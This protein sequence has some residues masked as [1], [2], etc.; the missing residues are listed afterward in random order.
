LAAIAH[1]SDAMETHSALRLNG[2]G[3]AYNKGRLLN[4]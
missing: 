2:P 1:P 4:K 3:N